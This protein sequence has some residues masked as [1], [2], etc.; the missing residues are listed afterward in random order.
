MAK[1]ERK[2]VGAMEQAARKLDTI[3]QQLFGTKEETNMTKV[4]K[5]VH[6]V[7]KEEA[8]VTED[9]RGAI[10]VTKKSGT[11]PMGAAY[12]LESV[13]SSFLKNDWTEVKATAVKEDGL[14][15]VT[16]GYDTLTQPT[17]LTGNMEVPTKFE[18]VAPV[19]EEEPSDI[20]PKAQK[21]VDE[22][23]KLHAEKAKLE[24]KLKK[25]K[26]SITEYMNNNNITEIKGTEGKRV[27]FQDATASN[28][29]SLYTDYL[30]NDVILALGEHKDLIK[31]ATEVRVNGKKLEGVL[32]SAKLDTDVVKAVKATKIAN[33]GTP[34]FVVKAN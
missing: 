12:N 18:E 34:K 28:S 9:S 29:T 21:E 8:T 10:S 19:V 25:L 6:N 20:S 22:Y 30:V 1:R 31:Q 4:L 16:T 5:F 11:I 33:P 7:T 15:V 27:T 17:V 2:E 32:A 14:R 13:R 24:A 3:D 23:L 26:P